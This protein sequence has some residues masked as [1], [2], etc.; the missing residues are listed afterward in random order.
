MGTTKQET[1]R[2]SRIENNGNP[3]PI[4]TSG[5]E[6]AKVSTNG[7]PK[8]A[9]QHQSP[10]PPRRGLLS[11]IERWVIRRMLNSWENPR[12][13]FQL[14]NGDIISNGNSDSPITITIQNRKALWKLIRNPFFEFG[15]AYSQGDLD[16]DAPLMELFR[17]TERVVDGS[18]PALTNRKWYSRLFH[19]KP[20]RNTLSGSRENIHQHY[21]LGNDFYE[22]WLDKQLLYTC[23]YF[24]EP[25]ISLEQ[26]QIA[27]MDHVC[28]KLEIKPGDTVIEA[29]CGWGAFALHMARHYGARVRAYNISQEQIAYARERCRQERLDDRVEFIQDDWRSIDQTADVFASIGMLEHVGLENYEALGRKIK[30]VLKPGGRALIHSIGQNQPCPFDPWIERR[31]FPGAYPPTL[32]EMM[33]IFESN[34]FSV[35]DV[36][37]IR[38]HYAETLWHWLDRFEKSADKV[39]DMFDDTFVRAWRLYLTGSFAAF[40]ADRLQLY[41]VLFRHEKDNSIPRTRRYQYLEM[42]E[43]ARFPARINPEVKSTKIASQANDGQTM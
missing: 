13:Q 3:L 41:Q 2:S 24:D 8:I 21:D 12:I 43:P 31:I 4:K 14:W 7:Q 40:E 11:K 30:Q 5:S 28:R 15:E 10:K 1:S 9:Q 35:L 37:N 22:M 27:K 26:A 39:Q 17:V 18:K 23:A 19:K 34:A 38:L 29:G 33:R 32:A 20:R 42:E 16:V 25:N 6:S 36:E